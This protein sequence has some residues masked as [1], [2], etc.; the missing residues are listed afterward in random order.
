MTPLTSAPGDPAVEAS[1]ATF[2]YGAGAVL[3]DIDL[4]LPADATTCLVGPNGSG[5][6]TL[7]HGIAGLMVPIA[8]RIRVLGTDPVSARSRIAYV[9]QSTRLGGHLPVTV[10]EIVA[11]GHYARLGLTGRLTTRDRAQVERAMQRMEVDGLARRHMTEL[12]GGQRQRVLLAQALVPQADILL[13]D[14]P[15]TGLD[16]PSQDR[17]GAVLDEERERGAT[18]VLT[19]HDLADAARADH[20]VLVAGRVVAAGPPA[21]VLTAAPLAEA[22]GSR[23]VRLGDGAVVVDDGSHH[24]HH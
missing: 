19:T 3:R 17:I 7:L 2:S 8:G 10:R 14:E 21:E 4:A 9:L 6:T 20:V 24:G 18:I 5:K 1:A 22:Y 11:M 16:L 23:L 12:S 15:V 13:L